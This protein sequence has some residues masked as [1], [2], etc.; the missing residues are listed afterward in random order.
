MPDIKQARTALATRILE[1]AGKV[2]PSERRAAFNNNGLAEPGGTLA[3]I[4]TAQN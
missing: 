4:S 3:S 2:S 1:G